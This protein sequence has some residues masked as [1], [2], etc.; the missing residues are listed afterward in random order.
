[1]TSSYML[2][3]Y[4]LIF[5]YNVYSVALDGKFLENKAVIYSLQ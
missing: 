4:V 5:I 3:H 1:M 2:L